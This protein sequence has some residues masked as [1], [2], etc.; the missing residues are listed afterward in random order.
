MKKFL[1]NILY[2]FFPFLAL[3]YPID[4]SL[5]YFLS[6]SHE[7]T[8]EFEVWN[9]IYSGNANCDIA[10]YG[11]SRAW[12][13]IDPQIINDSLDLSAYNFGI[14]GY[15]FWLQYLRHLEFIK[16][17]K[18]PKIII[19]SL[20]VFSLGRRYD[21]YQYEQ[22]LPYMLWNSNITKFTESSMGYNI[23]DYYIPLIR[24]AGKFDALKTSVNH[25]VKNTSKIS[26]RTNG[27][28]AMDIKWNKDLEKA[29]AKNKSNK[30][31]LDQK[32]IELFELFIKEC[33]SK[34]IELILV[35]SPEHIEGQNYVSNRKDIIKIYKEVSIKYQ[36][37]FFDYSN[38]S[39]CFNKK[40]FY[41]ALHLNK[42]GADIF[43]K[44]LV[45]DIKTR[46]DKS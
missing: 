40:L 8:G 46:M 25:V 42:N 16:Y 45:K 41:N 18:Q 21:L 34:R 30:V 6:K 28:K 26:Y 1:L 39:I 12:V 20:D 32:S 19:L 14:D 27:F 22:F 3:S 15:N 31:N 33:K 7:T 13:H 17:N 10:I 2:F 44:K 35:Y 24:Y 23:T 11:S 9:H 4:Y 37:T 36:L 43:S 5:S 38:D 29:K